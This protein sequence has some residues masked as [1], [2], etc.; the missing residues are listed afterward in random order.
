LKAN[1]LESNPPK[2]THRQNDERAKR[3]PFPGSNYDDESREHCDN[4]FVAQSTRNERC[5]L[6]G[7]VHRKR[8]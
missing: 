2:K 4:R 8:V 5:S 7:V 6:M 3:L 1:N